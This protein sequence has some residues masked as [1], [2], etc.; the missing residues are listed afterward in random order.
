MVS[1]RHVA[2]ALAL[3]AL[4]TGGIYGLTRGTP[5]VALSLVSVCVVAATLY[6]AFSP[7]E[8]PATDHA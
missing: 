3:L 1:V 8:A 4:V 5:I 7:P 6:L 2:P